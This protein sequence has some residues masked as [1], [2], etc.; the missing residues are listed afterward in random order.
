MKC[1]CQFLFIFDLPGIKDICIMQKYFAP[2]DA[3]PETKAALYKWFAVIS[4]CFL[5]AIILRNPMLEDDH[6]E[7]LKDILPKLNPISFPLVSSPTQRKSSNSFLVDFQRIPFFKVRYV[8][9]LPIQDLAFLTIGNLDNSVAHLPMAAEGLHASRTSG[10][11][12]EDFM[13]SGFILWKP[14]ES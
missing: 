11:H 14:S 9:L 6:K 8:D 13:T 4:T 12:I 2:Q 10:F 7:I 5:L 1:T 3:W